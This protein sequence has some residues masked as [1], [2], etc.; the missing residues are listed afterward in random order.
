MLKLYG[1]QNSEVQ[2]KCGKCGN[3]S[4]RRMGLGFNLC[5]A[6]SPRNKVSRILDGAEKN[7]EKEWMRECRQII[8]F[9]FN[10]ITN[11]RVVG[12]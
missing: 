3:I 9:L 1:S 10:S 4:E 12:L 11:W 5:V 8:G 2:K 7:L 6:P